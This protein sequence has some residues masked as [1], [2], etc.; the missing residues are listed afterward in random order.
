MSKLLLDEK[1]LMILP[2]LAVKIGLNEAIILQQVH[3]WLLH[4]EKTQSQKHFRDGYWWV[5]NTYE[6]WREN[7]PF[8]SVATIKRA[9]TALRKP[10]PGRDPLLIATSE[11]N[12]KRYDKTLWYRIDYEALKVLE[13]EKPQVILTHGSFCTNGTGQNDPMEQVKMTQPIPET[14]KRLPE[15]NSN[16]NFSSLDSLADSSDETEGEKRD[17]LGLLEIVIEKLSHTFGDVHHLRSN[18][19]RSYN[20]WTQAGLEEDI[21]ITRLEEAAGI[22]LEAVS[23]SQVKDMGKRMAYFFSVLEERLD[24]KD[25]RRRYVEDGYAAFIEH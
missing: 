17:G 21:F 24:L 6:N 16:S 20:L 14:T 22:T 19:T 7:F 10:A 18:I 4:Y 25:A 15:R 3:Y 8:W 13:D 5:Y 12:E 9:L 11:Y 23:K 1:P 2:Q